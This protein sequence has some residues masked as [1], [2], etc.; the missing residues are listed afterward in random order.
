MPKGSFTAL[1]AGGQYAF[2]V[3]T[4]DLVLVARVDRD[5]HL[6]EPKFADFLNMLHLALEAGGLGSAGR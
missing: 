5:K 6:P 2:V 1:G 3:P 4:A